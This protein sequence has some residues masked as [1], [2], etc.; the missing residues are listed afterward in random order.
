VVLFEL[1]R[2]SIEEVAAL[3][4]VSHSAVKSRLARGRKRLRRHYGRLGFPTQGEQPGQEIPAP[5]T[6]SVLRTSPVC[7]CMKPAGRTT[8]SAPLPEGDTP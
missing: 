2:F 4:G 5:D 6:P 8:R 3:Q 7:G 1:E